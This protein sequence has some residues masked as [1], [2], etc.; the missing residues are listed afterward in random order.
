ME[1]S[2]NT[3]VSSA[4][5]NAASAG[6]TQKGTLDREAFLKLLV[7]QLSHQDPLKPMEGTEFVTQLATFSSVEQQLIQSSK[8]D[9]ISLQMS[10][11]ANNEAAMLVGKEV[12]VKGNGIMFDGTA[13]AN[14]SATLDGKAESVTVNIYDA[15]GNLV[16]TMDMG[17]KGKGPLPIEW[18]GK[19]D[20]G[21]TAPPGKYSMEIVAKDAN[22]KDVSSSQTV[23]GTVESVTFENGYAELIL[24]SGVRAPVSD[25]VSVSGGASTSAAA[26][27]IVDKAAVGGIDTQGKITEAS[28]D[29]VLA[30]LGRSSE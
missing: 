20:A 5:S 30:A 19:T 22:G 7:A 12:T 2:S 16:K 14:A 4:V 6:G 21:A 10:G 18:D 24:D 28:L 17:A 27:S 9:L 11:L 3:Q 26:S 8:L 1:V 29:A 25:L 23:T 13:P 15:E